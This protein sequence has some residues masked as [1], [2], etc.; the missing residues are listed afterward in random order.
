MSISNPLPLA[1]VPGNSFIHN[2]SP[3][4]KMILVVGYVILAFSTQNIIILYSMAAIAFIFAIWAGILRT[5]LK[6]LL[7]L[8]P[9]G[10]SLLALQILAP[11][12]EK[13]WTAAAE[14][15]PVT[16]YI[17]GLYYGFVLLGRI[18]AS[19]AIALVML[20]T[21][22]P[23]D[24]FTTFTKLRVPYT[25][26]FMQ[27]MTLQLIPVFQREVGI[28]LSAQ[29]SRG[30]KG[31]GFSAVLPSFIPVF[32]GAIERVQQLSISLE[33]RGFGSTGHKT[34]YRKVKGKWSDTAI[35]VCSIVIMATLAVMSIMRGS[36][37]L[38]DQITFSANFVLGLFLLVAGTFL[39]IVTITI[40]FMFRK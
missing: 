7:I 11:A 28:I 38:S 30:M 15:G 39:T 13:P 2:V 25:L 4:P 3:G 1:L 27:A 16:L 36:W 8:L 19:L 33:S 24:M 9:I 21:T 31:S 18:F 23:S 35:A 10:S 37:N 12:V 17:D 40:A 26:N 6:G 32:V 20:M 29:K 5:F 14:L 34:S 22:H